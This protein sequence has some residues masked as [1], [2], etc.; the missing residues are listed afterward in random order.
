MNELIRRFEVLDGQIDINEKKIQTVDHYTQQL[1]NSGY[2]GEEARDLIESGLKCME[3][4]EDVF[5]TFFH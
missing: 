1:I 3:R 2:N 4:K 5:Y